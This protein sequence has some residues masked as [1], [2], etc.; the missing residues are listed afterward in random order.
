MH[1]CFIANENVDFYDY[2]YND[3]CDDDWDDD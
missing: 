1:Y 2:V 3:W